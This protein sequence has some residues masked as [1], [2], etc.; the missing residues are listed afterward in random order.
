M[1]L[2]MKTKLIINAFFILAIFSSCCLTIYAEELKPIKLLTPQTQGGKPLMQ[3]LKERKSSREFSQQD[4]P[5]QVISDM[6]WAAFGINRPD[7]GGRTAPSPMNTQEIDIYVVKSQGV[8]LYDAKANILTPVAT[9]DMRGITGIQP[10]VAEA[11]INL[12]YVADL[13]KMERIADTD[14]DFYTGCDAGFISQNVYLYCASVGL[15]T[16]VRAWV[17][18]P[19]LAKAI[20]LRPNQRIILAQTVGYPIKIETK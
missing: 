12:I 20:K 11:P 3:A 18:K 6:L 16:V 19:V 4:L 17:D 10:F 8:Y 9:G 7:S 1:N 15:S 14:I 5:L 2:Q 13:S